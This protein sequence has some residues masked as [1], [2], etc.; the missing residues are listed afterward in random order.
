MPLAITTWNVQNL[1]PSDPLFIQKRNF[2]VGTL[3]ALGSDV[4][5]LQE[6]L[7][8]EALEELAEGTGFH[9]H[10]APPDGRGNRVAFLTRDPVI[11]EPEVIDQWQLAPG[12]VVQGVDDDGAIETLAQFR[13]PALKVT[14]ANN[15]RSVDVITAHLKSKLL[16]FGGNF[17][18]N[19]ET[20]RARTAYFALQ[21]RAAEAATLR[22]EATA[23]LAAGRD[24][25]VLG[26]LNDGETAATTQILYGP[27]GSQ[28]RGP[29]DALQPASAFQRADADDVR[30]LFN[31]CGLV[32]PELRWSRRHNG[33]PELLDHILVSEG[34]MPRVGTLR[35]VP[36]VTILNEDAP[37][38]IGEHP[39]AGGVVPDHAP[40]TAVFV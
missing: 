27:P 3:L 22:E 40:V 14:V 16:T 10:A 31:V 28:P 13:R 21:L 11:G 37:N 18:T 38:L 7:D 24:M 1:D 8:L 2:I 32:A 25:I 35:Q 20:L 6:I 26:D 17:S 9:P 36:L 39:T 34:L 19:D 29:A 15:G 4:V 5:A 12:V 33:Q 30:R 23:A